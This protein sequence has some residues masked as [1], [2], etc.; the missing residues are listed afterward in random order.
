MANRCMEWGS[1]SLII[2]EIQIK[3][4][5]RYHTP[6][7][8]AIIKQTNKNRQIKNTQEDFPRGAVVES[9]PADAGDVGSCPGPG[10]S[11]M[12]QSGWTCEPWLLSLCSAT[13]EAT[14]VRGLH[15]TKKKKKVNSLSIYQQQ[16]I[17]KT[18]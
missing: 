1:T 16:T 14:T 18:N 4:T 17:R 8:M 7:R 5:I 9:L 3:I 11:H 12:P 2:R 6:V 15:T 10:R 13:G